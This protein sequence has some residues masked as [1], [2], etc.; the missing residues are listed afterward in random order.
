MQTFKSEKLKERD[1]CIDL[2]MDRRIL[3][4]LWISNKQNDNIRWH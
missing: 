3:L 1:H 2:D 4:I